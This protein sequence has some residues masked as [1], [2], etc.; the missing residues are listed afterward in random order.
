MG[1]VYTNFKCYLTYFLTEGHNISL[2]SIQRDYKEEYIA[3]DDEEREEIVR[4]H[5]ENLNGR[6]IARPSPRARV[7]DFSNTVRNIIM[8]VCDVM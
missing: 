2:L 5:K 8:L 1:S 7:Q 3:L 6:S 4:E